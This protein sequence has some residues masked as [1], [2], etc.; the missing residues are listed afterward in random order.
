M[1]DLPL[2]EM[3]QKDVFALTPAWTG[4]VSRQEKQDEDF[5]L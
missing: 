3:L 5:Y 4:Q 2:L 1:K